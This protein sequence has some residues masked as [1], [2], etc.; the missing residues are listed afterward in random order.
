MLATAGAGKNMPETVA[1]EENILV[2][3]AVAAN[4]SVTLGTDKNLCDSSCSEK[5]DSN[6]RSSS[7]RR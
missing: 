3:A 1:A 7:S 4:I 6:C 2:T 5:S